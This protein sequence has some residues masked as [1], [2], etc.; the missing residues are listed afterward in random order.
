ME[1]EDRATLRGCH[2]VV[3][4][5]AVD[6]ANEPVAERQ[7]A[8]ERTEDVAEERDPLRRVQLDRTDVF[9]PA[10]LGDGGPAGSAQVLDPL[11]IAP[12]RPDPTLA[13]DLKDREGGGARLAALPAADRD[14]PIEPQRN[15]GGD[16]GLQD[17]AEDPDVAWKGRRAAVRQRRWRLD[18]SCWSL[19]ACVGTF[20]V[21]NC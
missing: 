4:I 17:P 21:S 2:R 11:D 10:A 14:Q 15:A 1:L 13:L 20:G 19:L 9:V 3:E 6:E 16:Q 7:A 8:R 12:W 18:R 5:N